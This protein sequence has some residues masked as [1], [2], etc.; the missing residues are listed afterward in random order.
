MNNRKLENYFSPFSRKGFNC[1]LLLYKRKNQLGMLSVSTE[2]T[3]ERQQMLQEDQRRV[4]ICAS[5][6]MKF[7]I[8]VRWNYH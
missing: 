5:T 2:T 4:V 7:N 3:Q 1:V 6:N 8:K